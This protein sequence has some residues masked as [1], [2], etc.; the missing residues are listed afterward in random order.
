MVNRLVGKIASIGHTSGKVKV[1][2]VKIKWLEFWVT[3]IIA[4]QNHWVPIQKCKASFPVKQNKPHSSIKKTQF[5]LVLS[6]ARTA[7][8]IQGLSLKFWAGR[9]KEFQ[10]RSNVCCFEQEI[11][12]IK[13][14]IWLESII[15]TS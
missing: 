5:P 7:H 14:C 3:D 12:N 2:C 1:I 13:T 15:E 4:G 9:T 6:W 8:K 10:S 11:E